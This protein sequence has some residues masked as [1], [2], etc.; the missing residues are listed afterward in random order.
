MDKTTLVDVDL[1]AGRAIVNALEARGFVIDVAAWLQDDETGVWQLAISS[2]DGGQIGSRPIY[3]AILELLPALSI[4]ELDLS[5]FYVAGPN[6]H[7]VRDLKRRVGTDDGL[8]DI[9]FELLSVGNRLYRSARIYRV[10][11]DAIGHDARVRVKATG[12]SGTVQG[13]IDTPAG[14]R[15]LVL[16]DRDPDD[17]RRLDG[18]PRPP[19]G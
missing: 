13:V 14:P 16:Y 11:G 10:R 2:P 5:D 1:E 3:A 15:Y 19:A 7:I 4:S 8:H 18:A 12:Q 6:Q 9:R 17:L